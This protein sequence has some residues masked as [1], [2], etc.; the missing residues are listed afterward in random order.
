[1][2]HSCN[3]DAIADIVASFEDR[4]LTGRVHERPNR[5]DNRD[6]ARPRGRR[7]NSHPAYTTPSEAGALRTGD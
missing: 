3:L 2:A 6:A 4:A 5:A 1:M 7:D